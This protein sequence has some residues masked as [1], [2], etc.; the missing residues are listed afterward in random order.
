MPT[1]FLRNIEQVALFEFELAGQ[2]SD[3]HWENSGPGDHW[4]CWCSCEKA[5]APAGTQPGR[6]FWAR[7][8]RYGL[9]SSEL[10][11][12]VGGRMLTQVRVTQAMGIEAARELENRFGCD[13]DYGVSAIEVPTGDGAYWAEQRAI[14]KKYD[15]GVVNTHILHGNYGKRELL[16]DLR[17][18]AAAMRNQVITPDLPRK[19]NVPAKAVFYGHETLAQA[20]ARVTGLKAEVGKYD[21]PTATNAWYQLV[22]PTGMVVTNF[23][24]QPR[25][26]GTWVVMGKSLPFPDA[27]IWEKV[28]HL[29]L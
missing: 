11:G 26:D 23:Q 21:P 25:E 18:I 3:G 8:D 27:E 15:M 20:I 12:V 6:N 14:M 10:L 22:T 13:S 2:I 28:Q 1:L 7:R 9:T 5:V 29:G 24:A 16:K 17:E 19:P 4:K